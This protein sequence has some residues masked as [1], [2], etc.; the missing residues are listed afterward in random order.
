M[1]GNHRNHR[2]ER[3][4]HCA[5]HPEKLP[6]A[7]YDLKSGE[8]RHINIYKNEMRLIITNK[9]RS[10][11][12]YGRLLVSSNS[13]SERITLHFVCPHAKINSMLFRF[14][15]LKEENIKFSLCRLYDDLLRSLGY[16]V[17]KLHEIK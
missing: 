9:T 11:L 5:Y 13:Y 15:W 8:V 14:H 17:P 12:F 7:N 1:G 3:H 16:F 2:F 4:F 6:Q 10:H